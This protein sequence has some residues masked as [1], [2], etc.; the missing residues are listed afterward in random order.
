MHGYPDGPDLLGRLAESHLLPASRSALLMLLLAKREE[1]S[2]VA[3]VAFATLRPPQRR[4]LPKQKLRTLEVL[5]MH[6]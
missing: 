3:L 4:Q 1:R 5:L 2:V 6:W